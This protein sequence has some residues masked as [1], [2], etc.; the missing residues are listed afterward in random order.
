MMEMTIRIQLIT[1]LTACLPLISS[2]NAAEN[3]R[4]V[5]KVIRMIVPEPSRPLLHRLPT[6]R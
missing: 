3:G 2:G 5:Q 4:L 1:E 6:G